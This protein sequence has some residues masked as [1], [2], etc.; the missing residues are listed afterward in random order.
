[1]GR[2]K[3]DAPKNW[4][5]VRVTSEEEKVMATQALGRG[6]KKKVYNIVHQLFADDLVVL[7]NLVDVNE[8]LKVE[9]IPEGVD[10]K[11]LTQILKERYLIHGEDYRARIVYEAS[12]R[13]RFVFVVKLTDKKGII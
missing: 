12:T 2:R 3:K 4:K 13:K 9:H 8:I 11:A 6:R 7:L 1:M 5:V 10:K